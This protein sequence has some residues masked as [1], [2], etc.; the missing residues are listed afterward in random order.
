MNEYYIELAKAL[1]A[2]EKKLQA[3]IETLGA[4][5]R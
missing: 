1:D 2:M 4:V 3:M 5:R